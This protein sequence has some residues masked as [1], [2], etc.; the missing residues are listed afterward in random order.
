MVSTAKG[1]DLVFNLV[2]DQVVASFQRLQDCLRPFFVLHAK[3]SGQTFQG[4]AGGIDGI[5][6]LD[7]WQNS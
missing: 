6:D 1:A 5:Q 3:P 7:S 2:V 4:D